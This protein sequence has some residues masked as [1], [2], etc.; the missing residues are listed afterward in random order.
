MTGWRAL[1]PWLRIRE[2]RRHLEASKEL[3]CAARIEAE[4][5]RRL[6]EEMRQLRRENHIT[7]RVH[8][9]LRGGKA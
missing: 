5:S 1:I 3:G 6:A 2:A 8:S 9:A 7:Q 4:R